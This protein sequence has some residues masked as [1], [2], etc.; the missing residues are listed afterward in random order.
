MCQVM[1]SI[2]FAARHGRT[3]PAG[4]P[5]NSGWEHGAWLEQTWR[6]ALNRG[7]FVMM[8]PQG[9]GRERARSEIEGWA[10]RGARLRALTPW[11]MST[12]SR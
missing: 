1:P 2:A 7:H 12:G 6:G 8:W 3:P 11:P 5:P 4:T 9:W 10:A